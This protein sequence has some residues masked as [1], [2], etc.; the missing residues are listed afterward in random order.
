[1]PFSEGDIVRIVKQPPGALPYVQG[2]VGFI[3]EIRDSYAMVETI[4]ADGSRG[5]GGGVPFD[6]LAHEP[7]EVWKQA[8]NKVDAEKA[9]FL[10]GAEAR[11]ARWQAL[12]EKVAQKHSVTVEAVKEIYKELQAFA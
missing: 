8:K 10:A 1:M 11:T 9:C 3:D 4:R 12:L 2:E 5:G 6:C 7:G